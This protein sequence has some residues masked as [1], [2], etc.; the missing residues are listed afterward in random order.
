MTCRPIVL[1]VE[2]FSE[3]LELY[4]VCLE[5][6]GFRVIAAT[7]ADA[8]LTSA[9]VERPDVIV[10]DGGLPDM[11]SWEAVR[12]LKLNPE[13]RTIPTLMLAGYVGDDARQRAIDA[14]AIGLIGKPCL[15]AELARAIR[16][17]LPNA[18]KT[19]YVA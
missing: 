3:S 16:S 1:L 18:R 4:C 2:D 19:P 17:A 9:R 11:A 14:G 15:P 8:G 12:V 5:Q 7:D 13:L 10:L 6:D